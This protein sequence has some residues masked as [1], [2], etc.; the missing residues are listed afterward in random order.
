MQP[1]YS[2]PLR[3]YAPPLA[4]YP[5]PRLVIAPPPVYTYVPPVTHYVPPVPAQ[6]WYYCRDVGQYY[7]QV[8][9]CPSPWVRVLPDGTTYD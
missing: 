5:A 6:V 3:P 2:P 9:Y 8:T 7:P 4:V 1:I